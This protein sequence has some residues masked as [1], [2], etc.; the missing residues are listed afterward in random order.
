MQSAPL[1]TLLFSS[2][3]CNVRRL[4][5]KRPN[6]YGH[7]ND[8][9]QDKLERVRPRFP[10]DSGACEHCTRQAAE[11]RNEGRNEGHGGK[12]NPIE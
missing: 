5:W 10:S 12:G 11:D 6:A 8:A 4:E 3:N 9:G 1:M 2:L 7:G